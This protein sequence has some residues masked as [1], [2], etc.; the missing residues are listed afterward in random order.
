[1]EHGAPPHYSTKV[2]KFLKKQFPKR[3]ISRGCDIPWPP[4]SPDLNP[5]NYWL[6]AMLKAKFYHQV[7]PKTLEELKYLII[8]ACDNLTAENFTCGVSNIRKRLDLLVVVGG[9]NFEHIKN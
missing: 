4:R 7:T 2:R 1:M 3:V 5:L 8:D 9:E 6:W